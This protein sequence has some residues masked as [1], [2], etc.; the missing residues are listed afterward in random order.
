MRPTFSTSLLLISAVLLA[1]CDSRSRRAS[2]RLRTENDDLKRQVEGLEARQAEL[3]ASLLASEQTN[4][5]VPGTRVES[6]R[7]AHLSISPLSGYE[8][9]ETTHLEI[10]LTAADG[11]QRPIQLHGPIEAQVL[12]PVSGG[13]PELVSSIDMTTADVRDAWRGGILGATY[14]IELPVPEPSGESTAW[15]VH[16]FH[17]DLH[18]GRRLEASGPIAHQPST[19]MP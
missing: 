3:E 12:R 17:D 8:T 1:G 13:T 9:G 15:I 5:S 11:R 7:L 18:T 19:V 6:P 14:L 10:H 4:A 16:I 2:A